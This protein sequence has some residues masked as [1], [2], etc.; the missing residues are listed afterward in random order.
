M[1]EPILA[2]PDVPTALPVNEDGHVV[3][4]PMEVAG[5]SWTV[6]A[7]SMGNPHAVVFSRNNSD[8]VVCFLHSSLGTAVDDVKIAK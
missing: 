6:T 8:V 5:D 1:G 2:G 7:V 3:R 4:A